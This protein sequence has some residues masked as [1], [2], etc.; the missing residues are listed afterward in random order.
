LSA[1]SL[2]GRA[3]TTAIWRR[4]ATHGLIYLALI[5]VAVVM[6]YP[7]W[8]MGRT[9][10]FSLSQY[11][12]GHGIS[13]SSWHDLFQA[14]PVGREL[15]N[16]TLI[17]SSAIALILV[18]ATTAGYALGTLR[19]R[20]SGVVFL[21]IASAMMV[22]MQSMIIPEFENLAK[23]GFVNHYYAPILVYAA[24]GAPFATFLMTTYFRRLPQD[25]IEASLI[26]GLGY[27]EIFFRIML[28][29][30]IPAIVTVA[31]LQFIQIWDDLLVGL[32]FLQTPQQRP[33]TVGLATIPSQHFLD[34]PELM[35]GSLVSALPAV[36]VYLI[37]QRY[38]IRGLTMGMSK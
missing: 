12:L 35:A 27:G 16:S 19:Y 5:V 36:I 13:V 28:P 24:L 25:V 15:F 11:Y 9:S 3:A 14:L 37:F 22:P 20:F 38:L 26:D 8:F 10:L 18:S 2:P 7:F 32:L 30:A 29:L 34:V 21:V 23:L 33:L 4:R 1:L 6:L 31:V 17:A